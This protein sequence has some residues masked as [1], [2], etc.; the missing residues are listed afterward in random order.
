[1]VARSND[2][3][4]DPRNGALHPVI[5]RPYGAGKLRAMS[6]LLRALCR[7]LSLLPL[8]LSQPGMTARPFVT[9]DARLTTAGSCQLE[10]WIRVYNDN[11]EVWA[12]PACNPGGNFE[13]TVGVGRAFYRDAPASAD[14]VLQAKTLLRALTADQW[15]VGFAVGTVRHPEVNPGPNLLGNTYAYVPVSAAFHDDTLIVHANLGW[16]H[17]RATQRD[18]S[19][20]GLGA[21]LVNSERVTLIAETYGDNRAHPYW[22]T[23]LRY[24]VVP[25]RVQVDATLG[26]QFAAPHAARWLS[27]G[28]RLT[29]DSLF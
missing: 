21:E 15:G 24:A 16:L 9:D 2:G 13:I 28:L 10:S 3:G 4:G 23:G 19:T 8:A 22:Q 5:E 7:Y 18:N 27:I 17:D 26:A 6:A 14:Y 11:Q 20:W 29:P 12:L 1:M 25:G